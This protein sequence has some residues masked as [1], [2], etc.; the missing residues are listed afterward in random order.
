MS[1]SWVLCHG[2]LNDICKG[3]FLGLSTSANGKL[4]SDKHLI[5]ST[6][7]LITMIFCHGLPGQQTLASH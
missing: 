6:E 7:Y 1:R 3:I 2:S 5:A 4:L